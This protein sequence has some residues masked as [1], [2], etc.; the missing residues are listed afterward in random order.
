MTGGDVRLGG[1]ADVLPGDVGAS[2]RN[3]R[4]PLG[5]GAETVRGAILPALA[6]APSLLRTS[7]LLRLGAGEL[8]FIR[9]CGDCLLGLPL[10][11]CDD[12]RRGEALV[13][14]LRRCRST[15]SVSLAL[16]CFDFEEAFRDFDF[17]P[18]NASINRDLSLEVVAGPSS[19]QLDQL[20]TDL[21]H[22]MRSWFRAL[23]IAT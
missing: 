12:R 11:Y 4:A 21:R 23:V 7:E 14:M 6:V 9:D 10:P 16:F 22:V 17:F 15:W 19:D 3:R 2:P 13:L 20:A 18:T 1:L 8:E 5:D